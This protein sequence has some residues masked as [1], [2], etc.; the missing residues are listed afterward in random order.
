MTITSIDDSQRKAAKVAGFAY[1][2]SLAIEVI[3]EFFISPQLNVAGNAAETARN[4]LAHEQLFRLGIACD[5]IYS[6]GTVVLLSALYLI[7]K[8]VSRNLALLATF[9]RLIYAVTWV[10]IAVNLFTALRLSSGAEYL[11]AFGAEQLQA[12]ARLHLSGF[13]TY[14]VGLL[15]YGLASTVCAYLWLESRYIPRGLAAWGVIASA[16]CAI[17]TL[18]FIITPGFSK[19]VNLWWFDTPMGIFELVTSFWLLFKGLSPSEI[20]SPNR[21][22]DRAHLPDL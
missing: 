20:A 13:D 14:Y 10:V 4:I 11:Q 7:L 12:L 8:P 19:V 21:P 16:W 1:L 9:W 2:F 6:A 5:L 22:G 17:C 3:H 15:F 18:V